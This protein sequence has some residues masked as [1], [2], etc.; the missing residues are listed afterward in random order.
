MH[1]LI[2][3]AALCV[4]FIGSAQAQAPGQV[5]I[6]GSQ[7]YFAAD[8]PLDAD[9]RAVVR[10]GVFKS[11]GGPADS[12]VLGRAKKGDMCSNAA[13]GSDPYPG[14]GKACY[15][16]KDVECLP[17][18]IGGT[19]S[20][21]VQSFNSLG[22]WAGFWCKDEQ[23]VWT[24]RVVAITKQYT[25]NVTAWK[26]VSAFMQNPQAKLLTFGADPFT[27]APLRAVWVPEVAKLDAVKPK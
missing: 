3:L 23:G 22:A 2:L 9:G 11:L 21:F 24:P 16:V 13:F 7:I 20:R 4:A 12:F 8:T 6:E 5:G 14:V 10:Y 1:P 17:S 15:V 25:D 27:D 18:Q 26:T 19:G